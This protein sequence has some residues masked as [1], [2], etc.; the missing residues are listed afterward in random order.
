MPASPT[1]T[2]PLNG[3]DAG[4]TPDILSSSSGMSAPWAPGLVQSLLGDSKGQ[5]GVEAAAWAG[6]EGKAQTIWCGPKT[7]G[8]ANA[9]K[10]S[11]WGDPTTTKDCTALAN[12]GWR[13][14]HA[15]V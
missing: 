9:G 8:D 12:R 7:G 3:T 5:E 15:R 2:G 6:G 11:H 10:R 13:C 14:P 1:Q 4:P